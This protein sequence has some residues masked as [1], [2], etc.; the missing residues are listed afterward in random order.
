MIE[1]G[2]EM[3]EGEQPFNDVD[4]SDKNKEIDISEFKDEMTIKLTYT[5]AEYWQVKEALAKIAATPEQA[6]YN[7]LCL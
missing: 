1:W 3:P 4:Y 6:V 2:L 7:L 5:E